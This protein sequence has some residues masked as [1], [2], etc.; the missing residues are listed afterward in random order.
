VLELLV[1]KFRGVAAMKY[2]YRMIEKTEWKNPHVADLWYVIERKGKGWRGLFD[3]WRMIILDRNKQEACNRLHE[4]IEAEKVANK[5]S[6]KV[7]KEWE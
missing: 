1:G 4:I 5:N 7:I 3:V 6:K 2:K